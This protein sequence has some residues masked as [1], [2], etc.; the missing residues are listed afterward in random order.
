MGVT[1]WDIARRAGVS[2]TTVSR[3]LNDKP[4]ISKQTKARILAIAKELNYA[5]N[6]HAQ[7]LASGDSKTLGLIVA[8]SANPFYAKLTRGVEDTARAHGYGVILCNTSEDSEREIGAHQML[9]EKRVDGML[10][11]SILTGLDPLRRLEQESVPF[12]LLNRYL[13]GIDADCVLNGAY[14]RARFLV[15]RCAWHTGTELTLSNEIGPGPLGLERS[16][17][18]PS[19]QRTNAAAERRGQSQNKAKAHSR[20]PLS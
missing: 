18:F 17:L 13:E 7:A 6:V 15:G 3:A 19:S 4:D 14:P 1:M 11:T 2:V 8:D 5:I 20:K 10:I 16:G 9:R 12:V